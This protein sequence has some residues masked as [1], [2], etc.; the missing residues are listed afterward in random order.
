MW[1]RY[2]GGGHVE[3][4]DERDRRCLVVDRQRTTL[5]LSLDPDIDADAIPLRQGRAIRWLTEA[6]ERGDA[7]SGRRRCRRP[8]GER[9]GVVTRLAH[10]RRRAGA[11]SAIVSRVVGDVGLDAESAHGARG[12]EHVAV[13]RSAEPGDLDLR[14]GRRDT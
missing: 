14:L 10:G 12:L 11:G 9:L 3:L 7:V 8:R 13:H 1:A 5:R 2:S 4:A 6:L